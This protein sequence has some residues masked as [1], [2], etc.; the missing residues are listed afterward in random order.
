[1]DEIRLFRKNQLGIGT[2]RI[3]AEDVRPDQAHL[4]YAHAV[5]EGGTEVPHRDTIVMNGSGRNIEEQ[6]RLERDSR[7]RRMM[8]KGYKPT[9]DEALLGATNQLGLLNPMLAQTIEKVASFEFEG[10]FVQPK[11]DGHRCMITNQ[12]GNIFAYTRKGRPIETIP[13]VLNQFGWLLEG[14]TVDGELYIHGEKLQ[15][16]SSLIKRA[17]PRSSELRFHWYD[18]ISPRPFIARWAEMKQAYATKKPEFVDLVPTVEVYSMEDVYSHF[19]VHRASGYEGTMVRRSVAGYEANYRS[20]QLLKVKERHDCEVTVLGGRPSR[21]G[22]AI[23]Q[24]RMDSGKTFDVSAPGSVIEKTKV[25]AEIPKYVGRRLTIEYAHLTND[26]IPFHA[27]ALRWR[28]D[29]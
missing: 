5:T 9:R 8:D 14:K 19:K 6:L 2:W 13:H 28:E 24:V 12:G 17:Q 29:L 7:V 4:C 23:L 26:G 22:W 16:I 25:L 3:W 27:V 21:E 11:L 18:W 1:M 10:V 15:T 20:P